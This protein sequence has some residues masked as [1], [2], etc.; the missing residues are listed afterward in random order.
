MNRVSG[1]GIAV[2]LVLRRDRIALPIWIVVLAGFVVGTA[3]TFAKSYPTA[4]A[5]AEFAGTIRGNP[6]MAAIYGPLLDDG[7]GGLTAWRV[8]VA[9]A[10]LFGIF[11]IVTIVR[12]SRREE[13]A[14]RAELLCSGTVGKHAQLAAALLVTSGA[15]VLVAILVIAGLSA[16]G[17]A[18]PGAVALAGTLAATGFVLAA[19][20]A[21]AAQLTSSGRTATAIAAITFG[22]IVVVRM[23]GDAASAGGSPSWLLWLSP[24]GWSERVRPFASESWA[25]FVLPAA[26]CALLVAAAFAVADRRDVGAGVLA[27]RPGPRTAAPGLRTALALAWRLHRMTLLGTAVA[28]ALIGLL[29]GGVADSVGSAAGSGSGFTTMLDR[30]HTND[31]G[32][33]MLQLLLYALAEVIAI[34]PITVALRPRTEET[35]GKAAPLLVAGTSRTKWLSSHLLFAA[36][37]PAVCLLILGATAGLG[38][39]LA[40]GNA[41]ALPSV[42]GSAVAKLPALW[43][44]AGLST[45]LFGLIPKLATALS[46]AALG[47]ILLIEL[48][49]ELGAIGHNV[50]TISPFAH[51]YPGDPITAAALATLTGVALLLTAAG[52]FGLRRRDLT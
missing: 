36:I 20:T 44:V 19:V 51:V 41:G 35:D 32:Q 37:G 50:F 24:L 18:I 9:G 17:L 52:I 12:H 4:A 48:G 31:P 26:L 49:W 23:A 28:C 15:H 10:L 47:L 40:T 2:R 43:V 34:Y 25:V 22:V 14:G 6:A 46:W 5:R 42:L 7:I 27:A 13:E 1:L 16:Q 39:S 3:S 45:A 11:S 8:G 33:A 21:L 30:L 29:L 38:Y